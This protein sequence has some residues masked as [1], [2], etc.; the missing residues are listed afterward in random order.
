MVTNLNP[1]Q[2]KNVD[3][4][5]SSVAKRDYKVVRAVI[6]GFYI[7]LLLLSYYMFSENGKIVV[8]SIQAFV[9]IL[10]S[11]IYTDIRKRYRDTIEKIR[12]NQI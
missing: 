8:I 4:Y 5:L 11:K 12:N 9:T 6:I 7:I 3:E 1:K 2:K 10:F